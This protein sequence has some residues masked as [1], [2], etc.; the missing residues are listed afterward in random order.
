MPDPLL[1]LA[2]EAE[3]DPFFLASLLAEFARDENMSDEALAAHLGCPR[4]QLPKLKLCR[5]PREEA[6]DFRDDIDQ[7]ARAFGLDRDRFADAVL[8]GRVIQRLRQPNTYLMMAARDHDPE[9][10]P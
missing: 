5:P 6:A 2:L 3:D 7:F 10:P 9:T 8:R 4:D 1:R